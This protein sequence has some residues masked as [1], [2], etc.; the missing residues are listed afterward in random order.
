M[1]RVQFTR[2]ARSVQLGFREA[3][4]FAMAMRSAH[5]PVLAH[6]VPI[7]R[8]NLSCAYCNEFD[9]HSAPVPL[10][11]MVARVDKLAALGTTMITISGGEPLLHPA[12][13][14]IV[15]HIRS[16]SILA[17]LITNG[18]LITPGR[19][20]DLNAAGLDHLQIS[21]DNLSPDGIS[22][23]SLKALDGKLR[24]LSE[25]ALF[26]VDLNS[27]IGASVGAPRDAWIIAR[28]ASQLGFS[29]TIGLVHNSQGQLLP[30]PEEHQATLRKIQMLQRS[31][32]S[33]ARW[34]P[35]QVNLAL[36]LPNNWHCP[37]GGRYLYVCEEG[38]VHWCSQQRGHPGIPLSG[39]TEETLEREARM[40]KSCAPY[41]T[42]GCVHRVAMLDE[43]RKNPR[44]AVDRWLAVER[45]D[46]N[47]VPI[48]WPV[49]GLFWMFWG[50]KGHV[51]RLTTSAALR[52]LR[53]R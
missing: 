5:H 17:T 37:A 36:G 51:R 11:E 18:L 9:N 23:K 49:R 45:P 7:R 30:L 20:D 28:R 19:I 38:L 13:D 33:A 25:R 3:R 16:R 6:I 41:C 42:I 24:L 14:Q 22:K 12:L 8:C 50:P 53:L 31:T 47:P 26:K 48:P 52:L 34:N 10:E 32:F 29:F 21:I 27:V 1:K 39:Y 43:L 35:F 46:R 44:A 2:R 40:P 15:G 4:L